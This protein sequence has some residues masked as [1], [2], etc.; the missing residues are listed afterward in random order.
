MVQ[1]SKKIADAPHRGADVTRKP[2]VG[3]FS[4][5]EMH[6]D[7]SNGKLADAPHR[8]AHVARKPRVGEFSAAEMHQNLFKWQQRE[9]SPMRRTAE[10]V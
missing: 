2:R 8:G 5:T 6:N 4:A 9:N 3:E 1:A 10:P 7:S